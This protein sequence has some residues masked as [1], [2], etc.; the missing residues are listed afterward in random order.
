MDPEADPLPE[1]SELGVRASAAEG[2]LSFGDP[3]RAGM[4]S[5]HDRSALDFS[6][7]E[8]PAVC[9]DSEFPSLVQGL[10]FPLPHSAA[11]VWSSWR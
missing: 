5:S 6:G 7:G 1:L 3:A 2:A 9:H 8:C 10:E 11:S 4:A